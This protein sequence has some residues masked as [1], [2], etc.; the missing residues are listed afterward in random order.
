M[1]RIIYLYVFISSLSDLMS[2][3]IV[4]VDIGQCAGMYP[5]V[6]FHC[7]SLPDL[8]RALSGSSFMKSHTRTRTL[9]SGKYLKLSP[10]GWWNLLSTITMYQK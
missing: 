8:G 7:Q 5:S 1:L 3:Y 10:D 6:C 9:I 4:I 2:G